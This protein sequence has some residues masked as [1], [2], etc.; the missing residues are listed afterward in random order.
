MN[1][2]DLTN[3]LAGLYKDLKA[4]KIEPALA[5][6]LNNTA[7]NIQ[8]VVRLGLLNAKMQNRS[9]DLQFFKNARQAATRASTPAAKKGARRG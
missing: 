1:Y 2:D 5:H 9:P 4:K 7:A 3:E 8:G 6:E